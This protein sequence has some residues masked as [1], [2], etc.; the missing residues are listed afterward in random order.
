MK[1]LSAAFVLLTSTTFAQTDLTLLSKQMPEPRGEIRVLTQ[2]IVDS[3]M[4]EVF[5]NIEVNDN[6]AT[7]FPSPHIKIMTMMSEKV[8]IEGMTLNGDEVI[9][10]APVSD[11]GCGRIRKSRVFKKSTLL[12]SGKC[13]LKWFIQPFKGKKHLTI[14]F[15][16]K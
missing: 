6:L 2:F 4:K 15:S 9:Y 14:K 10:Q 1:I 12:L 16:T 13:N 7:T 11:V 5:A 3:E 8:K